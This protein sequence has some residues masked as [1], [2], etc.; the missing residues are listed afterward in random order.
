VASSSWLI[1]RN[2]RAHRASSPSKAAPTRGEVAVEEGSERKRWH[3]NSRAYTS[4]CTSD[5]IGSA[6]AAASVSWHAHI[7]GK[8]GTAAPR[9]RSLQ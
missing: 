9:R 2:D 6:V 7:T 3:S 5:C 1:A 8:G 4:S